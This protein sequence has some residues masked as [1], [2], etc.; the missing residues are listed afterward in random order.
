MGVVNFLFVKY[1]H[2]SFCDV[3]KLV[4]GQLR[5]SQHLHNV[6]RNLLLDVLVY[7]IQPYGKIAKLDSSLELFQKNIPLAQDT[8]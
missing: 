4:K 2:Q 1:F 7:V 6:R 5:H 8:T 3:N